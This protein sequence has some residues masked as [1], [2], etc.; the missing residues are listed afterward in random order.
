MA[1]GHDSGR[2]EGDSREVADVALNV[3]MTDFGPVEISDD[4]LDAWM[5]MADENWEEIV[6]NKRRRGKHAKWLRER[7]QRLEVAV[8]TIAHIEFALGRDMRSIGFVPS[9]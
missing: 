6:R 1:R 5:G 2:S 7:L 9:K 8:C 4:Y 3:I